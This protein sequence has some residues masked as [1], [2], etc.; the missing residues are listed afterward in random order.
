MD[1]EGAQT[2]VTGFQLDSPENKQLSYRD[3]EEVQEKNWKSH[4]MTL[5]SEADTNKS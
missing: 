2:Y 4:C 3:K 5:R 1:S